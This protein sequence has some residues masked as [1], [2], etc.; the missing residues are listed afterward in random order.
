MYSDRILASPI[1]NNQWHLRQGKGLGFFYITATLNQ[2]LTTAQLNTRLADVVAKYEILRTSYS[3]D[4]NGALLQQVA[5]QGQSNVEVADWSGLNADEL[6]QQKKQTIKALEASDWSEA[7]TQLI[8]STLAE[9]KQWLALALPELNSDATSLYLLLTELLAGALNEQANDEVIQYVDLSRWLNDFV[10]NPEFD[11]TKN[12]WRQSQIDSA[13][14]GELGIRRYQRAATNGFGQQSLVISLDQQAAALSAFAL[15]NGVSIDNLV[16]ASLR[17]CLRDISELGQLSRLLN[18]RNDEALSEAIGPLSR[19]VPVFPEATNNAV[20]WL[21]RAAAEQQAVEQAAD[22]TELFFRP[23]QQVNRSFAFTFGAL[24]SDA[25]YM[26]IEQL[27]APAEAGKVQF[28]L[29]SQC[30][31]KDSGQVKNLS[32]QIIYDSEYVTAAALSTWLDNWKS[33]LS[34]A[35]GLADS[36]TGGHIESGEMMARQSHQ[37]SVVSWFVSSVATSTAMVYEWQGK[38]ASH[39]ELDRQSN[40]LANYLANL[41]IGKGD[42]VAL[43][44][45]RSIDFIIVMLAVHKVGGAYMPLD[46]SYPAE[47]I[48]AMVTDAQPALLVGYDAIAD[49]KVPILLLNE[50][51]SEW[52]KAS[53]QFNAIELADN[54]LAYVLYTSGSSGKPKGVKISQGA[55]LNHMLWMQNRFDY[56]TN[57]AF[58]QRTSC[59]FDASVWEFWSPLLA[60]ADMVIA[61]NEANYNLGLMADIIVTRNITVL[62]MVPSQLQVLLENVVAAQYSLRWVFCG[63]EALSNEL[64]RRAQQQFNCPVVNLYGPSECCIDATYWLFDPKLETK[65]VPIGYPIANSQTVVLKDNGEIANIGE[66]GELCIAGCGVF[67]GYNNQPEM[68]DA[69]MITLIVNDRVLSCYKT[70]DRV[71]LLHDGNLYFISRIDEQVKLNG[72]RIEPDEIALVAEC[73]DGISKAVCLFDEINHCLVLFVL[74]EVASAAN[75]ETFLQSRLPA[76]MV[77]SLVL[78][79]ED[80]VYLANGKLD[81]RKLLQQA[82][83]KQASLYQ[84]PRNELEKQLV[85]IWQ[86]VLETDRNI[87]INDNFFAIGGHSLKAMSLVSRVQ[88]SLNVKVTVR[89]LFEHNTIAEFAKYIELQQGAGATKRTEITKFDIAN[90][91]SSLPLSFAQ[92]RLW[93]IEQLEGAGAQYN[94][95]VA[96]SVN[97]VLNQAALQLA[98]NGLVER[99]EILRTTYNNDFQGLSFQKINPVVAVPIQQ[100]DLS[101]ADEQVQRAKLQQLMLS[102]A[103][104]P[105]DLTGDLMLR[106]S[107]VT[108]GKEQYVLLFTVHHIASDAW[109]AGIIIEEFSQLY[110]DF[111]AGELATLAPLALQYADYA[112]WQR[113]LVDSGEI[114]N[115]LN[116]WTEQLAGLPAVHELPLNNSRP[117]QPQHQGTVL[118]QQIG[119]DELEKLNQLAKNSD[120]TLFMVLHSVFAL[121]LGRWSNSSDI[122]I[123]TPVAGRS[124]SKLELLVGCFINNLVLRTQL[125]ETLSFA[126]LLAASKRITLDAYDNQ[127]V[128]FEMLVEK[129]QPERSLSHA[130]LFQIMLI[131]D[132]TNSRTLSLPGLDVSTIDIATG[133][134]K[135]DLELEVLE[136]ATGLT[137][138]W[139][140]DTGLFSHNS[141]A[142]MAAAF[143]LL[144]DGVVDNPQANIYSLPM[145]SIAEQQL[146]DTWSLPQDVI[147]PAVTVHALFEKQAVQQPHN[148]AVVFGSEQLTYAQ[149]NTK[150]NQLAWSLTEH[151]LMPQQLVAICLPRNIDMMVAVLA[152]LKAGGAYLPLDPD[153]PQSRLKY[154]LDDAQVK[155]V[156]TTTEQQPHLGEFTGEFILF[157]HQSDWQNGNQSNPQNYDQQGLAYVIYTSGS[158]GQPKGVQ[159]QHDGLMNYLHHA[160]NHYDNSDIEGA[161]V[162]TSLCFDATVTTLFTPLI[163]GKILILLPNEQ[164]AMLDTLVGHITDDKANWL[165]KLTPGHLE[166]LKYK[167]KTGDHQGRHIL[168]IGGEQLNVSL[169]SHWKQNILPQASFVNEYGPTETVVGCCIET[170]QSVGQLDTIGSNDAMSIGRPIANTSL[171]VFNQKML[172]VPVGVAGE[173]FIGGAGV[174]RGYLNNDAMT[175]AKFIRLGGNHERFYRTGDMVKYLPDGRLQFIGRA[176]E[177][178]KI[179][180]YRIELCEIEA[181]LRECEQ[182]NQVVVLVKTR[183]NSK[184]LVAYIT[185]VDKDTDQQ[186]PLI[187]EFVASHLPDYMRPAQIE[188]VDLIPLNANGKVDKQALLAIDCKQQITD[189]YVAPRN[190]M[191]QTMATIW[192]SLLQLEKVGIND[193]FFTVGGDSILSIQVVSRANELGISLTTRQLFE[194]QTIANI[195]AHLP[196]ERAD[197]VDQSPVQG[198]YN[199]LPV[200]QTFVLDSKDI[201]HHNQSVLLAVRGD[202]SGEMLTDIIR[203]LY[204]RHDA[205]R[206]RFIRENES[207]HESGTWRGTHLPLSEQMINESLAVETL[208]TGDQI[209]VSAFISERCGFY[210]QSLNIHHGPLMRLVLLQSAGANE[211]SRLFLVAHHLVVDGVSWRILLKDIE[212]AYDQLGKGEIITLPAKTSSLQQFS[213]MLYEYAGSERI[214][215]EKPYWLS[216]FDADQWMTDYPAVD[217]VENQSSEICSLALSKSRTTQLLKQCNRSYNTQINELLLSA[218]YLAMRRWQGIE[219]LAISLE[220]H[221]REELFDGINL[222]GTLGCFSSI[223]PF[224]ICSDSDAIADVIKAVKEQH[225]AIPSKG[226]GYGVLRYIKQDRE[227]IEAAKNSEPR[228]IFNYFGQVDQALNPDAV[229]YASDENTG[230]EVSAE[231]LRTHQLGL[232][233]MIS[234]GR[235]SFVLNYSNKQYKEDSM[236]VL[237]G[238]IE[239]CLEEVIEHCLNVEKT[240]YTP[241]D[242]PLASVSQNELDLWQQQYSFNQLYLA[243]GIQQGLMFHSLMDSSAYALQIMPTLIGP[244]DVPAFRQ[245]WQA[246][247]DRY[248]IF[249][250]A[251]IGEG[252]QLHQLVVNQAQLPWVEQDLRHLDSAGQQQ[253]FET[254]RKQDKVRGFDFTQPPLQRVAIFRM[255]DERYQILW[256]HHHMILDGWSSP[257]VYR[258]VITHYHA[259]QQ[260]QPLTLPVTSGFSTY[261]NWLHQQDQQKAKDYWAEYLAPVT[262]PT[263]LVIDGLAPDSEALAKDSWMSLSDTQTA[264]LKAFAKLHKVTINTLLQLAWGYL[265]HRYSG[266]QVVSFGAIIS[267]RPPQIKDIEQM[268]GVFINTIPVVIDFSAQGDLPEQLVAL[269]NA[270]QSST[271]FGY[272][273]L[274]EIQK[275]CRRVSGGALFN[276]VLLFQN[277]PLDPAAQVKEDTEASN[278]QI[279]RYETN[280]QTTYGLTI[281]AGLTNSLEVRCS[282][283]S[284][285]FA[286]ATISRLL[287]H[288][289][290]ALLSLPLSRHSGDI[291][292]LTP[293]EICNF[294][295]L[296]DNSSVSLNNKCIHQQFEAQVA[297]TPDAPAVF[298]NG[299]TLSYSEL[300][301][302][303]NQ[304]AGYLIDKGVCA[305]TIVGVCVERSAHMI[306]ALLGILKAGGAY[307]PLDPAYPM[308]RLEYMLDDSGVAIVV[309]QQG[310]LQDMPFDDIQTVLMDDNIRSLLFRNQSEDNRCIE[311]LTE[312]NLAY[313]IYTSGSTGQPKG[314][315]LPHRGAVNLAANFQQRFAIN[316][317]SKVLLFASLSFDAGTADWLMALLN[318][319]CLYVCDQECR[320]SVDELSA[321][322]LAQQITHATLPP[323]LLTQMDVNTNYALTCLIVA[324]EA[325]NEKVAWTWA[326]RF[327]MFNA[328]GPTEATVCATVGRIEVGK[329]ITIGN[330]LSNVVVQVLDSNGKPQP[331]GIAGELYIGGVGLA[332]G[333]LNKA[334]QTA[335]QFV[336]H[337]GSRLY[338]T[339]DLVKWLPDS[340]GQP[341]VLE[342]IGRIDS[343]V[344]IRGFRIELGEITAALVKDPNVNN[345]AVIVK[346]DDGDKRLVAYLEINKDL[347]RN[348]SEGELIN[349]IKQGLRSI[350]PDYMLPSAFMV[351]D[352]LPL[353]SNGKVDY[354]ALPQVDISAQIKDDYVAPRNATEKTLCQIWQEL[355][356]VENVGIDDN[357]FAL[358]GDSILSIQAAARANRANI[359]IKNKQFF[360]YPTIRELATIADTAPLATMSQDAVSGDM[361]LLPIQH[362][363]FAAPTANYNHYNQSVLLTAPANISATILEQ[364][365]A[366]LLNRHD[367]LRLRFSRSEVGRDQWQASFAEHND[368]MVREIVSIEYGVALGADISERAQHYQRSLD[369]QNGQLFKLAYFDQEGSGLMA[370]LLIVA[371]HLIIDGVS[372]RVLL[373]DIETAFEQISK[374]E[375]IQLAPKTVSVQQWSNA[376]VEHCNSAT[377]VAGMQYWLNSLAL[378]AATLAVDREVTKPQ[379]QTGSKRVTFALDQQQTHDLLRESTNAYQT[380]INE[381]L[382]S[383]IYLG[384]QQVSGENSVRV[385]MEG[386]GREGLPCELDLTQTLGWFTNLYPLTLSANT[387]DVATV[388]MFTKEQCRA[389]PD[390]GLGYGMLRYLVKDPVVAAFDESECLLFNYLG[391]FDQTINDNSLFQIAPEFVGDEA[392]ADRIRPYKLALNGMVS[393]GKLSFTLDYS[394]SQ[395]DEVTIITLVDAIKGALLQVI[396]HCVGKEKTI[397]T[398]SDFPLATVTS[399]LLLQWQQNYEISKLYIATPMQQGLQFHSLLEKG[400]YVVQTAA[401]LEGRLD[402]SLYR[403]AWQSVIDK[404]DVFRTAFVGQ[405]KDLH[406][407]VS[408]SV[409]M[410]WVE[411]DW[412]SL[413]DTEQSRQLDALWQRDKAQG[414]DFAR[415]PLQR[416]TL[417]RLRDDCYQMLW[418][419]HHSIMDGWCLPLV[420]KSV[421]SAY[422]QLCNGEPVA[423]EATPP[424]ESYI[425]WLVAQDHDSANAYWADYLSTVDSAT[426]LMLGHIPGGRLVGYQEQKLELT[427]AQT[428]ALRH[429]AKIQKTTVNTLMQ[430]AW[431]YVL[432]CYSGQDEVVFGATI[433]GRPAE[434]SG[435]ESMVGLFINTIPVKVSFAAIDGNPATRPSVANVIGRLHEQFQRS[436]DYGFL[437]LTSIQSLAGLTA[438][439]ALFNSLILFENFPLGEAIASDSENGRTGVRVSST[440][441]REQ[442]N[443]ALTFTVNLQQTLEVKC[444]YQG[445][446]FNLRAISNLLGHL[447]QVLLQLTDTHELGSFNLLCEAEQ[448]QLIEWNDTARAYD[449]EICVNQ[450]FER[451]VYKTPDAI[452]LVYEQQQVSYTELNHK[453]NQLAR[454]LLANGAKAGDLVALHVERSLDMVMSLL[455]IL[456][457]G[458]AYVP[459]DPGY[460]QDRLQHMID[461]SGVK[462]L[463]TQSHLAATF[464]RTEGFAL[465][466]VVLDANTYAGLA[467]YSGENLQIDF[468]SSALAYVIYTSGSTG[469]PKGV[470]V[471]H[472]NVVNF[473]G[474]MED[475]LS[476]EDGVWLALTAI[477]F[478]ISVLEIF[479]SLAAGYKV[480]LAP[481]LRRQQALAMQKQP[482]VIDF[483]L[484]YFASVTD[485]QDKDIYKL[486]LDGARYAD[487]NG[488]SAVWTPER[489]FALFGGNYPNPQVTSA[490]IAA[491]TKNVQIRAGS[492]VIPLHDPI[493]VAEDWSVID[494]LSHGRTGIAFTSGWN[495]NDF[496]LAPENFE[497]RHRNMYTYI[498]T[499]KQLWRGEKITRT[500]GIGSVVE[501][502]IFPKPVQSEPQIWITAAGSPATFEQAGTMGANV[503]THLLGQTIG[504]LG[505]KIAIYQRA[506]R[507]AGHAG[508]GKVSLMLH[509]F[510]CESEEKARD[511]V[512]SP[513]KTYLSTSLGLINQ[514]RKEVY[515]EQSDIDIDEILEV[516]FNRYFN[517]AA[518]FGSPEHCAKLV[519]Q[520]YACGVNEIC[521]LIDFGMPTELVLQSL[522][523]LTRLKN[524]MQQQLAAAETTSAISYGELIATHKVSHIQCTPSMASL[525]L[526]DSHTKQCL[527]DIDTLLIGG[528]A[529]PL[530][531]KD[532]LLTATKARVIN[533]YGPTEAT[534]WASR[535]EINAVQPGTP[536]GKPL[537]NYQLHIVNQYMQP[538]PAG[539]PGEL[540]ISGDSVVP[541]YFNQVGLSAERFIDSALLQGPINVVSKVY[542]T[543]DVARYLADGNIEFIGRGDEQVKI[544]GFRIELSEIEM[545]LQGLPEVVEAKV[546][547]LGSDANKRLV[548]YV[549]PLEMAENPAVAKLLIDE[550]RFALGKTLPDQMVPAQFVFLSQMPLTPNGK[551]NKKALPMPELEKIEGEF[552]APDSSTEIKLA[553][554]WAGLLRLD[555]DTI[556]AKDNFFDLGGHSLLLMHLI[557]E[558]KQAFGVA[559]SIG[560]AFHYAQLSELA[561]YV[562]DNGVSQ[563]DAERYQKMAVN[564]NNKKQ[565]L[566]L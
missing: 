555:V 340:E 540:L 426:P 368:K 44:M 3:V 184:Q 142:A 219:R 411:E 210:Q 5:G 367:A 534:V 48:Q 53:I 486:L 272:L 23:A 409:I 262:S 343:Q 316:N 333:Y 47:R 285:K 69:A 124:H 33:K 415:A 52:A 79:L 432:H 296:S 364:I 536:I 104:K 479:G 475:V 551:V 552:V 484:F 182:V 173:L 239:S 531:L 313:V 514:L 271:D 75:L 187:S 165:F 54:D 412:R 227:L 59:S 97:G 315:L 160:I 354:K 6:A 342:F 190:A 185:L 38:S 428:D 562:D 554:I 527:A 441:V 258:D 423:I 247:V 126:E 267:G 389:V 251:F 297:L 228:L 167:I 548:A 306:V 56:A 275:Q 231:R 515:G 276:S 64:A 119:R 430:F 224:T 405:G 8:V 175:N 159:I 391:Q 379:S 58:L 521:C 408:D 66:E 250:T 476:H 17:E 496:A 281:S 506:R 211:Q 436:N 238:H 188:V 344:K 341:S 145:V 295:V 45:P 209:E 352:V 153:Y 442:T 463:I 482:E 76:Y 460:P 107:L 217:V 161:I 25:S 240:V 136:T 244:L 256:T 289:K 70:G 386:H 370:R 206:L 193:N 195:V 174:A 20:E 366:S 398:P 456:K 336:V 168:V 103:Q 72:F 257:V 445:E 311:G 535:Y 129:L 278:L 18:G 305:D 283:D 114:D 151:G 485:S 94:M 73:C 553:Q 216:Q 384:F 141:I 259:Y 317:D 448:Q 62:Q 41:G 222:T 390:G 303:A 78:C 252:M 132:N 31:D 282:Y 273:A 351:L 266:E 24:V 202:L 156:I 178:V 81:K 204:Q 99:H 416:V 286:S 302:Q 469:L 413:D 493:R 88:E 508:K 417:L 203:A 7:R 549:V 301:R 265:L 192:Q 172:P 230:L 198:D 310:L 431:A 365:A 502:E 294:A 162:A 26:Q 429:F 40:R 477:S 539:I 92:Q 55:L 279:E 166:I 376:L 105:V 263:P 49:I 177:Q 327:N 503:L 67:L 77:P 385:I 522:P 106:V 478:D 434:V 74:G 125:D 212:R 401:K 461:D 348:Q 474:G 400:A 410:P 357:F 362:W 35:L 487:Q 509:T 102:E 215:A 87:G 9:G 144:L 229:F 538:Q 458:C 80:F 134:I 158:T 556:S 526:A 109:S 197:T 399:E 491:I 21:E 525:M 232:N 530:N 13:M 2:V 287:G 223:F 100:W 218:V 220:G 300:N 157:D 113:K 270:F 149:L 318:G 308:E 201:H 207:A 363:F 34:M 422:Q 454:Y 511:I 235:L 500:N 112:A 36:N 424:Y 381:L 110:R 117:K 253:Y 402:T 395:Y 345:A 387:T 121:L 550:L 130:P 330:A 392:A 42:I 427:V 255:G 378:P 558:V 332:K 498:D 65:L 127:D 290:Q 505:D 524:M 309:T 291:Q 15:T 154:M 358:G 380:R 115:Q 444:G 248:D 382:L 43:Y 334:E 57:D 329:T 221:G 292:L 513:F 473:I 194:H 494:N 12:F 457:A 561:L 501:L 14:E 27:V 480:V 371:H 335:G 466:E 116:Y 234:K 520:V 180:G 39:A 63:G 504:E 293:E 183:N 152:V 200:Q 150:A 406:Q 314:V 90:R 118:R 93:F 447:Q 353:T 277:Y 138:N 11:E 111:A 557:T 140:Y 83:D 84:A 108:L 61:P 51:E 268:V 324:G 326:D 350:L 1:Q 254:Y 337:S 245:A 470:M 481:D 60:G 71:R 414:F 497:Q 307:L 319:A 147:V 519:A 171:K 189:G 492:C 139:N 516:A 507:A 541:G 449:A 559:L 86:A 82:R 383:A 529:F 418:T 208:P 453:A 284:G 95:P 225:R 420:Y 4:D 438:G 488:F 96:L 459:L 446:D 120:G 563:A 374:G 467:N 443:Y 205:L 242:F 468:N 328:Y 537:A 170:L 16:C 545:Q 137:L 246:V 377:F 312:D 331:V 280:E 322:M 512:K 462:L 356:R 298:F 135:Y 101:D 199:L 435:I 373:E 133:I 528:E 464:K 128:P 29:L 85:G 32:L 375:D 394:P 455:A 179:R 439:E 98:V 560:D 320:T 269:Q 388:I 89:T 372:W 369:I 10:V 241:A 544:R 361:P 517:S 403:Q 499:F 122:V 510:I 495:P 397:Y 213:H 264:D 346:E 450:L 465:H 360:D 288:L 299:E 155:W 451:Q 237:A 164:E 236:A 532:S 355:L 146:L 323:A 226:I 533:V 91:D 339:G 181:C 249:R 260:H 68:T 547:A 349:A 131:L 37:Q 243:T 359:V 396:A 325:V 186:L 191:E 30:G 566:T 518:L 169:V 176:D 489:H 490:A 274:G 542:R 433:S 22:F 338:K 421:M 565:E 46:V 483:S 437:P 543:G 393:G 472:Q 440:E 419:H 452:A 50:R 148:I 233:G 261:V 196:E 523:E 163:T 19:V 404:Y 425:R 347:S 407:L 28:L 214:R 123:G 471:S 321:Y 304:L 143:E 564:Q 546:L